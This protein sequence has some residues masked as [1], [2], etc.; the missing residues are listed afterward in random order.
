MFRFDNPVH[1]LYRVLGHIGALVDRHGE[2]QYI[3]DWPISLSR[4][5]FLE[6]QIEV[7]DGEI[8]ILLESQKSA[9]GVLSETAKSWA[10]L[11]GE[12]MASEVGYR[13]E[14]LW[15]PNSACRC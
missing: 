6:F 14:P 1:N 10:G 2:L 9:L 7:A 3:L 15:S 12:E 13:V 8:S 5:I 4:T 11:I